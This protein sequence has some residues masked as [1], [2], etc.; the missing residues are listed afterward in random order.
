MAGGIA[1]EPGTDGIAVGPDSA[2]EGGFLGPQ[3]PD[4]PILPPLEEED[5]PSGMAVAPHHL[6]VERFIVDTG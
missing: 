5:M 2:S 1:A 4:T 3:P 6:G